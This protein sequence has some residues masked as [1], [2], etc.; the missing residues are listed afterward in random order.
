LKFGV[1]WGWSFGWDGHDEGR[2]IDIC[3]FE[4]YIRS[5]FTAFDYKESELKNN[6]A[7]HLE[8]HSFVDQMY[9][10]H[11]THSHHQLLYL[12]GLSLLRGSGLI[13]EKQSKMIICV[14]SSTVGTANVSKSIPKRSDIVLIRRHHQRHG[15]C[16]IFHSKD[17]SPSLSL[18]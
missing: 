1:E 14:E 15:R 16:N 3:T 2:L 8:R 17:L 9:N 12:V 10:L 4:T 5:L 11:L 7:R 18:L 6:R 13:V